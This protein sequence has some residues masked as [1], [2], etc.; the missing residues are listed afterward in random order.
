MGIIQFITLMIVA[1][2][3]GLDPAAIMGLTVFYSTGGA[4]MEVVCQGLMVVEAR[5]DPLAGSEDLQTFAW[6]FY[7]IG[8]SIGC[9]FG[10][11]LTTLWP[12]GEGARLCYG[13]CAVFCLILG[14]AGPCINKSLESN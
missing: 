11:K 4:F 1:L 6:I 10:G 2:K 5:K 12:D 14:C 9:W 3:P 8:G 7:G 13:I